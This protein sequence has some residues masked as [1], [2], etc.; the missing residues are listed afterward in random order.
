MKPGKLD[1]ARALLEPLWET[2]AHSPTPGPRSGH[3]WHW[4][5]VKAYITEA[6]KLTSPEVVERRVLRLMNPEPAFEDD[7]STAGN[8]AAAI[9]ILLPGEKARPHRHSINALRFIME[10]HGATTIVNGIPVAMNPGDLL[11]TPGDCWHEHYHDGDRPSIWLDVLDAPVHN[12]LGII[13]FEPGPVAKEKMPA[14]LP[15]G[16]FKAPSIL[17]C[18]I[19]HGRAYSPVFSYPYEDVLRV[20]DHAPVG[21]EGLR[22]VRYANALTGGAAM[23]TLDIQMLGL[24]PAEPSRDYRC[25]ADFI[26]LVVDGEGTTQVGDETMSWS[27]YDILTIPRNNWFHHEARSKAHLLQVSDSEMLRRLDLFE[28]SYRS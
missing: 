28:E 17:P 4:Q 22:A 11:L 7:E 19:S 2:K 12:A 16:A 23:S 27:K 6:A 15:I 3:Q 26:F 1:C 14:S 24:E 8:L 10:G 21:P 13:T 5:D 25:N 20:L 18:G 9:Q